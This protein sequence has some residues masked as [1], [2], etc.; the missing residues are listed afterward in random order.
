MQSIRV[1]NTCHILRTRSILFSENQLSPGL[2]GDWRASATP[3]Y[4]YLGSNF[5]HQT[6]CAPSRVGRLCA[7]TP[8]TSCLQIFL[9]L[10]VKLVVRYPLILLVF[11]GSLAFSA[12]RPYAVLPFISMQMSLGIHSPLR[13]DLCALAH[14]QSHTLCC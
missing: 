5:Q 8:D 10:G 1:Y 12:H 7:V 4:C 13:V 2:R 9:T 3:V 14:L 6:L 11:D